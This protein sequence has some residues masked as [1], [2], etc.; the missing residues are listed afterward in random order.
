M[1]NHQL[2]ITDAGQ[3]VP[4]FDCRV[5]VATDD[6]TGRVDVRVAN[7]AGLTATASTER[8]ALLAISKAFKQKVAELH[9]GSDPIPW[10]DPPEKPADGESMRWI[11]VH[12]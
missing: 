12:L 1:D 2:P 8:D 5:I 11:P 9:A 10:I 7:L 6:A 3:T 4:V